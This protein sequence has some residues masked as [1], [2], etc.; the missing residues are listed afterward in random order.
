MAEVNSMIRVGIVSAVD[1]GEKTARVYFPDMDDM[2][3]DWLPVL[4]RPGEKL[5]TNTV[6][7]HSHS[8]TVGTFMPSVNDRVLVLYAY[9]FNSDCYILG[10]IE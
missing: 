10:V 4:Q 2:A 1:S 6:Q 9:G 3:S 5:S 7:S 8:G